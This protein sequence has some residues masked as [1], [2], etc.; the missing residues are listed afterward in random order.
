MKLMPMVMILTVCCLTAADD[1]PK[2]K[3][4]AQATFEPR[5]GP[6]AGQKLLENFVG[7]WDVAKTFYPRTGEPNRAKGECSAD[8]DPRRPIPPV[9]LRL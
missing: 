4:D 3:K 9:G 1:P 2:T 8:D 6:G 5:S 7:D